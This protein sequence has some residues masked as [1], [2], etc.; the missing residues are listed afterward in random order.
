LTARL[1]GIVKISNYPITQ[2][3]V[4]SDYGFC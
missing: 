2:L 4:V 1:T 3:G